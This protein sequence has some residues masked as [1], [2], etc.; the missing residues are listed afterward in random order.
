MLVTTTGCANRAA[1]VPVPG[2]IN[3]YDAYSFRIL[4]D[5]QAALNAFKSDVSSG[6]VPETPTL[7]SVLNQAIADY[8]TAETVYKAWHAVGGSTSA[9]ATA[10]VT[11]AINKVQSDISSIANQVMAGGGK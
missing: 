3:T 7:K 6:K 2:S 8:D 11:A 10:P 5:A 1:T 4:A 9:S